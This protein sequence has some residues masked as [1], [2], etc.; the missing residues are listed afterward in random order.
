MARP[1][2]PAARDIMFGKKR[3]Q[4]LLAQH[5]ALPMSGLSDA[6]LKA[7][8]GWQGQQASRDDMTWFGFRW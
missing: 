8:K 1:T 5:R 2:S 7:L 4:S 3:I 6:L